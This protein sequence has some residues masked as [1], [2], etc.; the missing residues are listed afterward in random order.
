MAL[1]KCKEC[2]K[3][4]SDM[5]EA[6]PNCGYSPSLERKKKENQSLLPEDQRKSKITAGFLCLFLWGFGAHEFYLG[7]V[8]KAIA[9]I[10][11]S[12]II[13]IATVMLPILGLL[14]LI[15]IIYAVKLWS[16]PLDKFDLKYNQI[17]SPKG[18]LGCLFGLIIGIFILILILLVSAKPLLQKTMDWQRNA[19]VNNSYSTGY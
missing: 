3:E 12:V 11:T 5:A 17:S 4:F 14:I 18:K 9:W 1:I 13:S 10:I 6:C 16:M 15:P 7:N 19:I 2:G 8:G